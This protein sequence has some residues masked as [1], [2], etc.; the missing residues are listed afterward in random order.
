[1]NLKNVFD[2]EIMKLHEALTRSDNDGDVEECWE[3]YKIPIF[4]LGFDVVNEMKI[5]SNYEAE[6]LAK[7]L[8]R[9]K[10]RVSTNIIQLIT[11]LSMTSSTIFQA[12]LRVNTYVSSN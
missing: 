8:E 4:E 10:L 2:K 1:M 9:M 3:A 11:D 5:L 12:R 6:K 7:E